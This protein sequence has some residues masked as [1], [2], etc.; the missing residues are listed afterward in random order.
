MTALWLATLL[1][2]GLGQLLRPHPALLAAWTAMA[3]APV[4]SWLLLT[5]CRKKLRLI[6][7]APGIGEKGKPFYL[8]ARLERDIWLPI[9]R[10]EVLLEL[11]NTA[12]GEQTRQTLPL[13]GKT[14]LPICSDYCGCISCRVVRL[15]CFEPFGLLPLPPIAG[16]TRRVV[17]MPRT[18]PVEVGQTLSV[19]RDADSQEYAPEQ[20]GFDRTETWQIREYVP[21]DTLQQIHWK[22]SSKH[23]RLMVREGSLPVDRSLTVFL[24]LADDSR[25]PAAADALLEA[26]SSVSQALAEAGLPFRLA[27]N[28]ETL[29]D[30]QI[31]T[32]EQLPEALCRLLKARPDP[33]AVPGSTIWQQE[34]AGRVLYFC[35]ILPPQPWPGME[36]DF[37][38]CGAAEA[39]S[40]TTFTPENVSQQLRF[41]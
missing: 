33:A 23:S 22:L 37:F 26:V 17:I 7:E 39:P 21:G 34:N 20:R 25:T 30:A 16:P 24:D 12:T 41:L 2:L 13:S 27:W 3:A 4:L 36:V 8:T 6:M 19:R 28:G 35:S 38:L 10:A 5:L 29:C 14:E 1:A 40:V 15:R 18:F 9:A 32:A 11:T 31:S